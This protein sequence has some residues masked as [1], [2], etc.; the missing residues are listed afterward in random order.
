VKQNTHD[1]QKNG[2]HTYLYN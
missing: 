1:F 2:I